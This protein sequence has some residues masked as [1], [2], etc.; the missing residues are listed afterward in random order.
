MMMAEK[1]FPPRDPVHA[2]DSPGAPQAMHSCERAALLFRSAL[3]VPSSPWAPRCPQTAER[4]P[5][6]RVFFRTDSRSCWCE[7]LSRGRSSQS[8][9]G[10]TVRFCLFVFFWPTLPGTF[11]RFI[12]S[13]KE[14]MVQGRCGWGFIF[15]FSFPGMSSLLQ[16]L[17]AAPG[18]AFIPLVAGWERRRL[19]LGSRTSRGGSGR[20]AWSLN[21]EAGSVLSSKHLS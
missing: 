18:L 19:S 3:G 21:V 20:G 17:L 15:P 4:E 14:K 6:V 5:S 2:A 10:K 9:G 8:L 7:C 11:Y 13:G 1:S 16:P 12:R